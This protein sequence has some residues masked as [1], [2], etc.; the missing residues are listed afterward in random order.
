MDSLGIRTY[1][2]NLRR[3][4]DR[5][6][7]MLD[8]LPGELVPEFTSDWDLDLDWKT[9]D[10]KLLSRFNL[11]PWRIESYNSWWNRYL[12]RGEVA[13]AIAHWECWCRASQG[14]EDR[15]LVLEDDVSIGRGFADDLRSTLGNLT[16]VDPNWDLLY[17]GREP[18]GTDWR[19]NDNIVKPGY[20]YG[21]YAYM[22]TK[23]AARKLVDSGFDRALIPVDEFLPAMFIDHPRPDVR[24]AFPK[25]LHAYAVHPD[26]VPSPD[27]SLLGSDTEE[28]DF[29]I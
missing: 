25:R 9:I 26:M 29:A 23:K 5:R 21:A 7:L 28:S 27:E 6:K 2:L 18:L 3:R 8:S 1:V 12:K 14:M 17:L 13:C 24:R 22:L 11:F 20:S 4:K 15:F 19:L 16:G 10:S